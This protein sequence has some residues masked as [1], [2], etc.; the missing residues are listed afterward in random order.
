MKEIII[1][2][3]NLRLSINPV[4]F[5]VLGIPVY[6]YAI[7]IVVSIVIAMIMFYKNDGKFGI[8]YND[9]VDLALILIPISFICARIYYIIFNVFS[10]KTFGEILNIKE[11]GLAIYGGII[12]GGVTSYIFCKKRKISFLDLADY[13][14][15]YVALRPSNRKMGKFYKRR[16]IRKSNGFALENGYYSRQ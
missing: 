9:I 4:A 12:G 13:I 14:I 10:Y 3:F 8:K 2:L 6:W 1:P 15:P 5:Y 16:S 7:L 11:G